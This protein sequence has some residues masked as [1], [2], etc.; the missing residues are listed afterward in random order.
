MDALTEVLKAVQLHSTV[1]CRSELSAPWGIRVDPMKDASFHVVT[2]GSCWLEV[3]GMEKPIPLAGGDLIVLPM[4]IGHTLRDALDSTVVTLPELLANRPCQGQLS[5]SYGGGGVPATVLCGR[6]S[7]AQRETNPLLLALPPLI[8]IKGE[9]GPVEWLDTTL[10]FIACESSI[11]RPGAEMMIAHLSS[12]LFIQAVRA[13]ITSLDEHE[14]GWLR[15]LVDPQIS[16]AL[17]LIH[18]KPE[19]PWTV[20]SLAQKVN[21]S[22]SAFAARFKALVGESPVQY[23]SRWR[24]HK[25][26]RLLHSSDMNLS[27]IAT[28]IG[29]ESEAAF[30]R[31]FKR[32]LG[33]SP[34]EYRRFKA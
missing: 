19:E 26:V 5:L 23:L 18:Q 6:A 24:M 21:L 11:S 3:D 27:A 32:L 9:E 28:L 13:Y 14:G 33:Q 34:G 16:L 30:S 31:A 8:H 22:R 2:R 15:A 4:G 7:F 10:Q 29:Y 1:H 25:A 17:G 20:K 12:I